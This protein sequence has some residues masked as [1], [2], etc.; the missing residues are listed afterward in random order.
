MQS[1]LRPEDRENNGE[2]MRLVWDDAKKRIVG[3]ETQANSHGMPYIALIQGTPVYN[4]NGLATIAFS[5]AELAKEIVDGKPQ[6]IE[7][8]NV[9]IELGEQDEMHLR[10]RPEYIHGEINRTHFRTLSQLPDGYWQQV[11]EDGIYD[12]DLKNVLPPGDRLHKFGLNGKAIPLPNGEVLR[13]DHVCSVTP[14][15]KYR[16]GFITKMG[17]TIKPLLSYEEAVGLSSAKGED[18]TG[19]KMVIYSNGNTAVPYRKGDESMGQQLIMAVT[20]FDRSVGIFTY[21]VDELAT[22]ARED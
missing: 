5:Q 14:D 15:G 7:G 1:L 22:Y 19:G 3:G 6:A 9:Q 21:D 18:L 12:V 11:G 17:N 8:K 13:I 16:Y 10:Y 4:E 20:L 2:D